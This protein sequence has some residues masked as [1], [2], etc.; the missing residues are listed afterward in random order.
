MLLYGELTAPLEI[1][2]RQ[3]PS[4]Y[5]GDVLY[6]ILGDSSIWF[7]TRVLNL[8]RGE[9]LEGFVPHLALFDGDPEGTGTELSGASYAR[10]DVEFSVPVEQVGGQ[11]QIENTS[12]LRF[13]SPTT[14]WGNWAWDGLM[15]A[16]IGGNL[17]FKS[18]NPIPEILQRNYV[19]QVPAGEYKVEVN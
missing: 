19:P 9:P 10:P 15:T 8:L 3:Q 17:V 5:E 13:P 14:T 11:S 18:Q 12:V 6:F 16:P 2:A 7:K 4:I 1:R